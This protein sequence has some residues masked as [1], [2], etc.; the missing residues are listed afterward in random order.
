MK[1]YTKLNVQWLYN[2]IDGGETD[3][4]DFKEQLNDKDIFDK[5]LKNYAPNYSELAKDVVAFANKKGGF[6]VLGITDKEKTVNTDFVYNNNEITHL[7]KQVQDLTRPTI[8]IVPHKINLNGTEIAILEIPFSEQLHCTSQGVYVIRNFDGNRLIEPHEMIVVQAEKNLIVYDRKTWKIPLQSKQIDKQGNTVPAWQNIDKL[9]IL[10]NLIKNRNS[11]SP[12]LKNSQTEFSETLGLVNEVDADILPTTTGI[13]FIGNEKALKE[14]PFAYISYIRYQT[15]GTYT[16]H[17]FKGNVIDSINACFA[18]LKSEITVS[19]YQHGLFRE[20]V[21]DYPE[22]VLRELIINAVAHR[23]YSRLQNIQ[24]RKFTDY[25]EIESPGGFPAGITTENYLRKSNPRN[26]AIMDILR[27]IGYAEKAGSGFDKIF[28]A[29]LLKGK[30]LPEVE[31]TTSNVLVRIYAE[32]VSETLLQLSKNFKVRFGIDMELDKAIILN[33][34]AQA[35][36]IRL[37]D[38]EQKHF[39]NKNRLRNLLAELAELEFVQKSGKT[40]DTK[41]IIHK[42]KLMGLNEERKYLQQKKQD[43]QKQIEAILRYL[44]EFSEIS[45]SKVRDLLSLSNDEVTYVSKLLADMLSKKLIEIIR[46]EGHNQRIYGL[47]R[48]R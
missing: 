45:N 48:E 12:Y 30:R 26:P 32:T 20:Y 14:L 17:E 27:E 43:R 8:T 46:E 3:T 28:T 10:Y 24:I 15:N 11:N 44:D 16:P 42:S 1:K 40:S 37:A 9:R 47:L 7:I 4:V 36:S 39:I 2:I 34:I 33:E 41:Y 38:L 19:E 22:I 21:E 13:L 31:E 25:L 6:I 23:D 18:Q 35:G 5:S 29:L